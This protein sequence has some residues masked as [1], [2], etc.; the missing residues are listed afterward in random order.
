MKNEDIFST[1]V[2]KVLPALKS[3]LERLSTIWL[4][5]KREGD[6]EAGRLLEES[7]GIN[8][9]NR[10]EADIPIADLKSVGV[11]KSSKLTLFS[12]EGPLLLPKSEIYERF[13]FTGK[14]HPLTLQSAVNSSPN[15]HQFSYHCEADGVYLACRNVDIQFWSWDLLTDSFAAKFPAVFTAHYVSKKIGDVQHFQFV[16][17]YYFPSLITTVNSFI[18]EFKQGNVTIEVRR[19]MDEQERNRGTAFRINSETFNR[20][21]Q[22]RQTII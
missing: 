16:N 4:P 6:G 5:R 18:S 13:A 10:H 2:E 1:D 3:E 9:N 19:Y 22:T 8:E 21:F 15:S 11:T 20:I 14:K 7:L 17:A 12:K